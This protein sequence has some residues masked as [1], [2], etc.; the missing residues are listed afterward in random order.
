MSISKDSRSLE[1]DGAHTPVLLDAVVHWLAPGRGGVFVDA[2]LGLGGHTRGLIDAGAARVIG[3]DRDRSTLARAR[4]ALG[5]AA[6]KVEMVHAD[7][8]RMREVL[9]ALGVDAV[10]GMVADLGVSSRQ[11]DDPERGFSFRKAGPLDMRL[12]QSSGPTLGER[13]ASVDEATLANVIFEFGEERHSRRIARAI[14]A[15]RHG[16]GLTDTAALASVVRRAAGGRGWQRIDPATRT[17]QALRIWTNDELTG[18][19]R[20]LEDAA[21]T[22]RP[23]GRLAVIAFH[24]LEDRV[25]KHTFRRLAGE[26]ER[27]DVLTRRPVVPEA[28]E[29][30]RNPRARSARL[31]VLGRVA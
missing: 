3:L 1:S 20:F 17:F 7:Y 4:A 9:T 30:A 19:D 8:R 26:G 25:V 12:D 11:L 13:L 21:T 14:V 22:L 29:S 15:A 27:F 24:S 2:T 18:L 6:T 16:A 5:D 31:R 23:G 10:D 28:E